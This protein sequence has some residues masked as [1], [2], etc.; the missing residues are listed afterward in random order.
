MKEITRE[1]QVQAL[2]MTADE[3]EQQDAQ[4]RLPEGYRLVREARVEYRVEGPG[5]S[6]PVQLD[7][8]GA[9]QNALSFHAGI[10][11]PPVAPE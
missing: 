3:L 10:T 2:R 5:F 4:T 1:Q 11:K 9:V 8:E 7:A 6:G